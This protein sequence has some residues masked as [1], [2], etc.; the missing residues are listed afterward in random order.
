LLRIDVFTSLCNITLH[1]LTLTNNLHHLHIISFVIHI[2]PYNSTN[3]YSS[4]YFVKII[5]IS[6]HEK[7]LWIITPT[8]SRKLTQSTSQANH[9]SHKQH[10]LIFTHTTI[11]IT[12]LCLRPFWSVYILFAD[13]WK[14]INICER[15]TRCKRQKYERIE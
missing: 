14:E 8:Y 6:L 13:G 2:T 10:K 12:Q 5:P 4:V 3:L 1:M 9:R 15:K 7:V 11:L